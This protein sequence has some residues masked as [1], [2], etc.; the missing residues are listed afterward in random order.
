MNYRFIEAL[1]SRTFFSASPV[2]I[3][4]DAK[5]LE[6]AARAKPIR[7]APAAPTNLA[8]GYTSSTKTIQLSWKDNSSNESGFRIYRNGALLASTNNASYS[9]AA[10]AAGNSY[11]Y[12]VTAWNSIGE[13]AASNTASIT[14]ALPPQPITITTNPSLAGTGYTYAAF[15][16][17]LIVT[18]PSLADLRQGY[19]GDCYFI[20]ALGSIAQRNPALISSLFT[21]NPDGT[22]TTH[23]RYGSIVDTVTLD[24]SLPVDSN[25]RLVYQGLGWSIT[26][27]SKNFW[28]SW[29][30]KAYVAWSTT[31]RSGQGTG[32][33]YADISGGWMADVYA[34]VLGQYASSYVGLS[35]SG[36]QTTLINAVTSGKAVTIGTS[37]APGNGLVANHAYV[38]S[39]YSAASGTF[40]LYNPWGSNQPGALTYAQLTASCSAFVVANMPVLSLATPPQ[41]QGAFSIDPILDL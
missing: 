21:E 9:D 18:A 39:G 25:G 5:P 7:T 30:E 34:Q 14:I 23:F 10:V 17:S 2:A 11:S 29:E 33:T 32:N 13:S 28:L 8:A 20:A 3:D 22:I 35:S 12:Y 31:G 40:Q 36:Y 1:E 41:L 27:T 19:V 24:K 37:S 15:S 16:Q 26:D 38:V 4:L 6:V